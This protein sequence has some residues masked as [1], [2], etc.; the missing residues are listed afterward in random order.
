M[1]T[2]SIAII[3]LVLIDIGIIMRMRNLENMIYGIYAL[4]KGDDY[5]G[6]WN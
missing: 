2:I 3:I 6:P 1:I 5:D 4:V